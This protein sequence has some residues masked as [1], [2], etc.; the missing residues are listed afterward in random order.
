MLGFGGDNEFGHGEP[1]GNDYRWV[2][3]TKMFPSCLELL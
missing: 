1:V 3:S 2:I